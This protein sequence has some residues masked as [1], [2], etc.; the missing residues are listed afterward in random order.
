MCCCS[1]C[2][3]AVDVYVA[4]TVVV[5]ADVSVTSVTVFVADVVFT[6]AAVVVSGRTQTWVRTS[7]SLA[8]RRRI[9]LSAGMGK[10]DEWQRRRRSNS[11]VSGF[12]L[13]VQN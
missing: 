8:L 12:D 10:A 7:S 9:N 1:F 5:T 11:E 6:A 3:A 13:V 4:A 2:L